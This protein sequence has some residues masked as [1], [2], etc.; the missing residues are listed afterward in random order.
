[1]H[2]VSVEALRDAISERIEAFQELASRS[3]FTLT[4]S[5]KQTL[6]SDPSVH[7]DRHARD[8]P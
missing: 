1:M 5:T 2:D 8:V 7:V 3:G 4:W 6:T